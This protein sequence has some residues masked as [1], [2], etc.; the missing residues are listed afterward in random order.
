MFAR[1]NKKTG[2]LLAN[3]RKQRAELGR[4][5]RGRSKRKAPGC[6]AGTFFHS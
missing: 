3:I 4:L 5:V 1:K 2:E 6:F